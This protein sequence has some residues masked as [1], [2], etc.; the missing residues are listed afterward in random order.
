M[1]KFSRDKGSRI[2][3]AIVNA[4]QDNGLAAER[5]P[6]SGAAHGRFGGDISFPLIGRDMRVE[7]KGRAAGFKQ[8]YRWLNGADVLMVR[9]DRSETLVVL[10]LPLAMEVARR[11]D[12]R[13]GKSGDGDGA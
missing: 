4:M 7:V 3:R 2:E 1:G 11:A 6:L 13:S 8:L 12:G 10:R 5:V 9:A